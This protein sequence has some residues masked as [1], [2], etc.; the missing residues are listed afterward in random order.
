MKARVSDYFAS[1]RISPK[2][3]SRMVAK[4]GCILALTFVP[5]GLILSNR[6]APLE[7][8]L[9]AIVM[10][11]GMAG[12]GFCI[13]H[14]ALHG[15]YASDPRLNSALGLTLDALGASSYLWKISHNILHHTYTNIHGVD[16][17]LAVSPLLRLSPNAE[18][19][20]YHRFQHLYA[21][22]LYAC[23]TLFW[24][25]IKDYKQLLQPAFRAYRDRR[26][27]TRRVVEIAVAK[28]IYYSYTLAVPLLVVRL[29]WWQVLLGFLA[30]HLTAGL[31]LGVVFQLAHVIED[32]E[33]PLPDAAGTMQRDWWLHEMHT[34]ANFARG[35]RLLSWYVGGL[36]HQIEH[37]LFPRVCS[38]HYPAIS[39]IVRDVTRT[40][41]IP[42]HDQ[43]TFRSALASH[44]RTLRRFGSSDGPA[45]AARTGAA[46]SSVITV[47]L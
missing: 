45:Y 22:A 33:H 32:T 28:C 40:Y 18:R 3:N 44:Y 1:R 27:D 8:L 15:A 4:G 10:G 43:P 39:G 42:Y 20:G 5:Y 24:V 46:R 30:M 13:A 23:T 17:D 25:F 14:D 34:T 36:N 26:N 9:L 6:V 16:E 7:M 19:R 35:N 11:V 2:A 38:I 29:P 31:I 21:F 41:G 12:I 37:H 47:D